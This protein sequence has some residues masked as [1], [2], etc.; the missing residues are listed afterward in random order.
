M[1]LKI[2][3]LLVALLLASILILVFALFRGCN[4]SKL[5]L[6]KFN[7][8]DSLNNVLLHAVANDK[9]ITDSTKNVYQDS[10]E[11]ER[12]YN[13]LIEAQKAVTE[14]ELDKQSRDNKALIAKYKRADYS[15][16]ATTIVP[17]D[18]ITD[19]QGCFVNL[20]K[21]TGLVD[22]YKT[23][24]NNL[25][26]NWDKQNQLYQKRFKELDAEKLGFYNKI[27]TLAKAQQD[28]IDKLKP[29]GRLYLST[30]IIW[31]PWPKMI[32]GGILYQN[33]RN[34]LLGAKWYYGNQG[35][36]VE[37]SINFPLSL[38]RK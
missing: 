8:I 14:M 12:G 33:K 6:T 11:F 32:G 30:G 21:T 4:Q 22:R 35:Q 34:L 2:H 13:A 28:A 15:D 25:Q 10:L 27:N 23:D 9:A 5:Q 37:T 24:I 16:T 19:C 1:S 26:N 18:F 3:P 17:N 20:E 31:G 7:K 29:H 38:R 36:M